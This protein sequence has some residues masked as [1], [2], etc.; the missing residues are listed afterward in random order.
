MKNNVV[1]RRFRLPRIWSNGVLQTLAPLCEGEIINVSGWDDRD[2]QGRRYRDYF[3]N[4]TSYSISNYSGER[5]MGDAS[6]VTDF[7]IDLEKPL[8]PELAGR[9]D[10][11]FNHTTLEHIF[12]VETAFAN[13]C[14]MSRDIVIV[15]V[16]F[17]Q[18]MHYTSSYGDYWR[19]TPI[20]LRALFRA[21]GMEVVYE[22]ANDDRNAGLYVLSVGSK[23]PERW[24]DRFPAHHKVKQLGGWIGS[25]RGL[26][27]LRQI[28]S[29]AAKKL[30]P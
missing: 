19:F 7:Q 11:V 6:D 12:K 8:A 2:K 29:A 5:G 4:A 24:R 17:A 9:F 26:P 15:V 13:L 18:E 3:V 16:P 30:I 22:A 20:G 23:H 28:L 25:V 14:A 27:S 10:V 21:N 1:S